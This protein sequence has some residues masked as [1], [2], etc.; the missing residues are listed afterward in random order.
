MRVGKINMKGRYQ[1]PSMS[2]A[3]KLHLVEVDCILCG[4]K[5]SKESSGSFQ[6][7]LWCIGKGRYSS[8][9]K[10]DFEKSSLSFDLVHEIMCS[11]AAHYALENF[12]QDIRYWKKS[13]K[14]GEHPRW[15]T[16]TQEQREA[17]RNQPPPKRA[18]TP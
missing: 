3:E 11:Y 18:W 10:V 12:I 6:I 5:M 14:M 7:C 4:L 13:G 16:L 9:P 1:E 8:A 2:W 17:Y 15:Q